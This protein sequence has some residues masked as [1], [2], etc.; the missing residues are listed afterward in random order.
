MKAQTLCKKTGG[1][2]IRIGDRFMI[3]TDPLNWILRDS[4]TRRLRYFPSFSQCARA[5]IDASLAS[6]PATDIRELESTLT[7]LE[8][9]FA[10]VIAN[11]E[12]A[13]ATD[14]GR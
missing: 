4:K 8:T 10:K 1:V 9:Q 14:S 5:A 2:A 11:I 6:E 3:S 7:R 12:R 13:D